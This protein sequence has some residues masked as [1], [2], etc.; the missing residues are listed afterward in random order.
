M[1]G[2]SRGHHRGHP[3]AQGLRGRSVAAAKLLLGCPPPPASPA[4]TRG[5]QTQ[6]RAAG[7]ALQEVELLHEMPGWVWA[8]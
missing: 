2:L 5:P 4:M 8:V 3:Q 1:W 7:R 6:S